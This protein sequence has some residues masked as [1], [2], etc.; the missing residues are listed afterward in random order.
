MQMKR[1][2]SCARLSYTRDRFREYV[3]MSFPSVKTNTEC[4]LISMK[5]FPIPMFDAHSKKLWKP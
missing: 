5:I 4:Y 2:T 1:K 3:A